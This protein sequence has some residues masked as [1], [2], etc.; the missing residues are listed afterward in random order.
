MTVT[1]RSGREFE[2]IKAD[3]KRKNEEEKQV[4]EEIKIGSS[5]RPKRAERKICSK[6]SQ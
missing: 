3:E 2:N 6:N 4:E 1:L 5:K